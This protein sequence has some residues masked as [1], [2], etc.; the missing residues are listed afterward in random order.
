MHPCRKLVLNEFD[1]LIFSSVSD[2]V[3]SFEAL[4][5]ELGVE[6]RMLRKRLSQLKKHGYVRFDSTM[7]R[8][9]LIEAEES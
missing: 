2:G 8:I 7:N 3:N 4:L 9:E 6:K 1:E 5:A